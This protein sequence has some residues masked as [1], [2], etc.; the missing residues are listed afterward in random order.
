MRFPI[1]KAGRWALF[2]EILK[3]SSTHYRPMAT[4]AFQLPAM[5]A[6]KYRIGYHSAPRDRL[7]PIRKVVPLS[8]LFVRWHKSDNAREQTSMIDLELDFLETKTE[9]RRKKRDVALNIL[10]F[11]SR[12]VDIL[13]CVSSQNTEKLRL[14]YYHSSRILFQRRA[15]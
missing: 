7:H 15:S 14:N 4:L 2:S 13:N 8:C 6:N 12:D 1:T 5:P 11:L 9:W 10:H 3:D